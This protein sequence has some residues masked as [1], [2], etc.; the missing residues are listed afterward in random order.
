V[1]STDDADVPLITGQTPAA[2]TELATGELVDITLSLGP[3]PTGFDP[4]ETIISQ[5]ANSPTITQLIASMSDYFD[6]TA[7]LVAF[8]NNVWNIDSAVGFGLDTWGRIVGIGRLLQLPYGGPVFG[9]YTGDDSFAPFNQAPF[10][11]AGNATQTFSMPDAPY[12]TLI[13]VKAFGNICRPTAPAINT[14]L[15]NLFEGR[16]RCYVQDYGNMS[17]SYTFEFK[18]TQVEYAILTQLG[19]PPRPAGVQVY[20]NEVNIATT[21]GFDGSGL[22][23]FNQGTFYSGA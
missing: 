11:P 23:P 19:V 12:R 18:L 22:Q 9:F 16:G 4:E 6:P 7:N 5:Y 8:Y 15:N 20:I 13:L 3:N 2:G 10:A 21:F 14:M 1:S 17:M